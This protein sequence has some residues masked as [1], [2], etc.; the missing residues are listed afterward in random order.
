MQ[1]AIFPRI[2]TD[3]GRRGVSRRRDSMQH[4]RVA[5]A[6]EQTEQLARRITS[7][8]DAHIRTTYLRHILLAMPAPEVADLLIVTRAHAEAR[9]PRHTTLL[10]TLSLA[11]A[12]ESCASLRSSVAALLAARDQPSLARSLC[13]ER[14]QEQDD[15]LRVPDFGMS[16]PVTLGERKSLAR[17]HDRTWIARVIRDPHPQVMRI[18]LQNPRLIESDVLRLCARRPVASDVLRE[19]FQ[20]A[21]WIVRYPIKVALALNPYTPL[22]IALQLLPLLHDQD[23]K[24]LLDA[25][26][27]PAELHAACRQGTD[28][29]HLH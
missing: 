28:P 19:V 2:M 18:L 6:E 22:D 21:R 11:L 5:S 25:A 12:D 3:P 15:A 26:D 20:C 10:E 16:R 7:I 13:Q 9:N 29:E 27:L 24:R 4:K 17:R 23:I 14:T 1:A 8:V